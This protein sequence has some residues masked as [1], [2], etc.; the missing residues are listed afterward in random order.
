[1]REDEVVFGP[2]TP[3][4]QGIELSMMTGDGKPGQELADLKLGSPH[5]VVLPDGTVLVAF[6]C[7]EDEIFNI[8]W[9]RLH[10]S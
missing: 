7:C 5:M 2:A 10:A 9:I 4:W 1:M 8:R 3:L 6:W